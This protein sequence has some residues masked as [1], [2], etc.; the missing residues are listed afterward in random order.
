MPTHPFIN[1]LPSTKVDPDLAAFAATLPVDQAECGEY[2][3][4]YW[5]KTVPA[6]TYTVDGELTRKALLAVYR[7]AGNAIT[8][9][10]LAVLLNFQSA[11]Q[12][13]VVR[14][15]LI[16]AGRI[17]PGARGVSSKYNK[18]ARKNAA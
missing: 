8:R 4:K 17:T 2:W 11:D 12:V 14:E 16:A 5:G 18:P 10:R 6:G 13:D 7:K 3:K 1:Q 9:H 15:S